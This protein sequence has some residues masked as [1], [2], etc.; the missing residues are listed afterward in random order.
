MIVCTLLT[1]RAVRDNADDDERARA[2]AR[3]RQRRRG[4]QRSRVRL[5]CAERDVCTR[6]LVYTHA[7]HTCS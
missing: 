5:C 7:S 1:V 6:V 2:S 3:R 4:A